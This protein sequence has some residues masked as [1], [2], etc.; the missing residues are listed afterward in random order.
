M[1]EA[2]E[3]NI[4]QEDDQER[5]EL[6]NNQLQLCFLYF[7]QTLIQAKHIQIQ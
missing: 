3:L 6:C 7:V 5:N 4:L 2:F 1:R